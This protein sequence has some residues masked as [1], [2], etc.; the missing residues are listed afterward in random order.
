VIGVRT[1]LVGVVCALFCGAG[2]A[3]GAWK[4]STT[5]VTG[6]LGAAAEFPPVT[7]IVPT[8]L[9]VA[10]NGL[11]LSA[12]PGTYAPAATAATL[13]WLRCDAAGA[14]CASAG[15]GLT[16]ALNLTAGQTVRVRVTPY[17]GSTPGPAAT[18]DPTPGVLAALSLP[19]TLTTA[20]AVTG[21]AAVGSTLTGTAGG[22][23]ALLQS[24]TPTRQWLRCSAVG[25]NCTV[26]AGA[27]AATYAP[28]AADRGSR[29]RIRG[30]ASGTTGT[31]ASATSLATAVVG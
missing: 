8:V 11:S 18:S 10:V 12:D 13:E 31:P 21:T 28:T 14:A 15:S 4:D 24:S 30:T 23:S 27:T 7:S 19:P 29:L 9:G 3:A 2:A 6:T 25:D 17:N 5:S 22:W 20:P 16:L 26:I 1:V